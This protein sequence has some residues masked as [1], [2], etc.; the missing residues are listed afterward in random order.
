M[1]HRAEMRAFASAWPLK[2]TDHERLVKAANQRRLTKWSVR[3]HGR[4]A[5][6]PPAH[7][8]AST[9]LPLLA[10]AGAGRY[11]IH[12]AASCGRGSVGSLCRVAQTIH[13]SM[14]SR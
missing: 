9:I 12:D 8:R 7:R 1:H 3:H 10:S 5:V 14:Y 11:R 2:R 4:R 13:L 6:P